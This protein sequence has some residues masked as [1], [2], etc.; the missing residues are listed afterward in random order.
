MGNYKYDWW[1]DVDKIDKWHK[2]TPE[3]I[4][5]WKFESDGPRSFEDELKS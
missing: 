5:Q 2:E 1:I 4:S 3:P